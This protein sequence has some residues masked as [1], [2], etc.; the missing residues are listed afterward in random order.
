MD[1]ITTAL[2]MLVESESF[3]RVYNEIR[4]NIENSD[5]GVEEGGFATNSWLAGLVASRGAS[6]GKL[7]RAVAALDAGM[8]DPESKEYR[9]AARTKI[10][11]EVL[12]KYGMVKQDE[13]GRYTFPSSSTADAGKRQRLSKF[14]TFLSSGFNE[15][16]VKADTQKSFRADKDAAVSEMIESLPPEQKPYAKKFSLMTVSA[17]SL[18]V[19]LYKKR[20]PKDVADFRNTI[21]TKSFKDSQDLMLLRELGLINENNLLN[22]G[23]LSKFGGFIKSANHVQL[24]ALNKELAQVAKLSQH[25]RQRNLNAMGKGN[26]PDD[27][28]IA[29]DD[30]QTA[31]EMNDD[32]KRAINSRIR[33]IEGGT[34]SSTR[35][36]R[37]GG[38]KNTFSDLFKSALD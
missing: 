33:D 38:Y 30:T 10:A 11:F 14:R 27:E 16:K 28:F 20:G 29:P 37:A 1:M 31:D 6:E 34:K 32:E 3:T 24:M 8:L 35:N 7:A 9:D 13:R 18:L 36:D 15:D 5:V 23:E 17:Y 19:N 12:Y 2:E 4:Q 25:T 26:G 21:N 22:R